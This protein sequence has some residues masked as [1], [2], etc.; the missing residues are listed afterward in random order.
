M[1]SKKTLLG[2]LALSAALVVGAAVPALAAESTDTA[3]TAETADGSK[4]GTTVKI[5]TMGDSD[6][7]SV[8]VP[9]SMTVVARTEG[10]DLITP[11][12]Y[13]IVNSSSSAVTVTPSYSLST[14][15]FNMKITASEGNT[16]DVEAP[17]GYDGYLLMTLTPAEGVGKAWTL[18][19]TA[20]A[21]KIAADETAPLTVAGSTSKLGKQQN[22][23][24]SAAGVVT[25][26]YTVE[27][28]T[29]SSSDLPPE[30]EVDGEE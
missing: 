1:K 17:F 16:G 8:T 11:D 4:T 27:K 21:W 19:A 2:A 3:L 23:A 15:G 10:G 30:D 20:P 26:K 6:Q 9:L 25:L 12:G 22:D 29:E 5:A 28:Y 18:G 7:V 13:K 14:A 24:A